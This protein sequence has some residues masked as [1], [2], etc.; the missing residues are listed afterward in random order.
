VISYLRPA[1][2]AAPVPFRAL[3]LSVLAFSVPLMGATIAPE[4]A[5]QEQGVLLW[6]T[7]LLPPFLL[8]YYRGWEG[9]S[10][11]LA[12]GMAAVWNDG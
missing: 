6:L 8:T 5:L 10:I 7:A 1:G 4:W 3:L 2:E 9:A 11:G 12:A